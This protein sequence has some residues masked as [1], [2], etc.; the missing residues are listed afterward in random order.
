M[1]D[2]R[3]DA[4]RHAATAVVRL[5]VLLCRVVD[6]FDDMARWKR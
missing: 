2:Y 1:S 5:V 6:H 3:K 4:A